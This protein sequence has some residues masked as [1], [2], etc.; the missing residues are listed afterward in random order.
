[1]KKNTMMRLASVLLVAV[2]MTTCVISGTF[3]KYTSK[4]TASDSARVAKWSFKVNDGEIATTSSPTVTF[5]LFSTVNE[6]DTTTSEENVSSGKIAPGTGGSFAI[7]VKNDSEVTAQYTITF[8][9]TNTQN[10]P[11]QYSINGTDWE[12]S[13]ADLTTTNFTDKTLAI[14]ASEVSYTVY[15]RWVFDGTTSGAHN[16]QTDAT[17][18]ALGIAAQTTAPTVEISMSITVTQVD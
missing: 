3:A 1:M 12:D 10:I 11:L 14:G 13:I 16:G 8:T 7:E 15:W 5:N 9:E 6:A 18:T 4:Y 2:L 17:D